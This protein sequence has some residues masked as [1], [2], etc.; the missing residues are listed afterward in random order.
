MDRER[1]SS[2]WDQNSNV[3]TAQDN[4]Q[5]TFGSLTLSVIF[6]VW[7][8]L[9]FGN[10]PDGMSSRGD[11]FLTTFGASML[12]RQT[13]VDQS[14]LHLGSILVYQTLIPSKRKLTSGHFRQL[15]SRRHFRRSGK[16]HILSSYFVGEKV[17]AMG[18]F[19]G[20]LRIGPPAPVELFISFRLERG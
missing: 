17:V 1:T 18:A 9:T 5:L 6:E 14:E 15:D 12:A 2:E 19:V 8:R 7:G 11:D 13:W 3:Q 10:T 4:E 16:V 20:T